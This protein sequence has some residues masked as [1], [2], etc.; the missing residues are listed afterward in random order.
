MSDRSPKGQQIQTISVW[1]P[2]TQQSFSLAH[3][4]GLVES[5]GIDY[6]H[7][8]AMPSPIGLKD[9]GDYRRDG[10]DTL[11]SNGQLYICKGVFTAC[12]VSNTRDKHRTDGGTVDPS[13]SNLIMPRFYNKTKSVAGSINTAPVDDGTRVYLAPGD[14]V[15]VNDVSANTR[16]VNYQK[17]TYEVGDNIP[18]FPILELDAPIIDSRNISYI[19]GLDF[20]ITPDG[21]I[22]WLQGGKNPNFDPETGKGRVYSIRYLYRAYWYVTSLPKEVRMTNITEGGARRPER[23]AYN[24]QIQREFVYHSQNRG[25]PKNQSASPT[26]GRAVQEPLDPIKQGPGSISVDMINVSEDGLPD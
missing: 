10:L 4:D 17:M 9:R 15:Y 19:Q 3:D 16:V 1:C 24:A 2:L 5:Q 23:M 7:W 21:N 13:T 25:D 8:A 26:P 12:E 14:R 20:C 18:M 11:T 22:S 6:Q